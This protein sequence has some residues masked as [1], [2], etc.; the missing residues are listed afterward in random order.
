M[1]K[2]LKS[3]ITT[4][5]LLIAIFVLLCYGINILSKIESNIDSI[6][7]YTSYI[8]DISDI[9]KSVKKIEDK[10]SWR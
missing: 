4:N 7:S 5:I 1:D 9:S 3:L 2:I 6:Y 8:S 10:V